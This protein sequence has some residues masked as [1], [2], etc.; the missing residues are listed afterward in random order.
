MESMTILGA[1]TILVPATDDEIAPGLVVPGSA[2]PARHALVWRVAVEGYGR[3]AKYP[4]FA[5]QVTVREF[6]CTG[7][8]D[9]LRAI[10]EKASRE[11]LEAFLAGD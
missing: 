6:E 7:T 10:V 9:D 5:H 2:T 11:D 4:A 8:R 1:R 3:D